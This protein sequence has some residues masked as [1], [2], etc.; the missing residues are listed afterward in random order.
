MRPLF[1]LLLFAALLPASVRA[2]ARE[3]KVPE[4]D[5]RVVLGEISA[6]AGR[7]VPLLDQVDPASWV[8]KGAPDAYVAQWKSAR[9]QAQALSAESAALAK[10]PEKLSEAMKVFFRMQSLEF[11]MNSL[12]NGV[13]RYHNPAVA[14][15][16]TS[17]AAENGANRERFQ[18]HIVD[19][20]A[21]REQEYEIMDYEAQRC[22]A[23][24]TR[25]TPAVKTTTRKKQ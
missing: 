12:G 6:H 19:L 18:R 1:T 7:L 22:R 16:L 21:M 15:L 13:R 4:A 24:L 2:Q 10:D 25:G 9:A 17:V 14:D 8:E 5:I 3:S 23:V 11:M 20:V